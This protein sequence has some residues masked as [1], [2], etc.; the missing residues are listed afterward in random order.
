M[1]AHIGDEVY[2]LLFL[3][4]DEVLWLMNFNEQSCVCV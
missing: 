4:Y 3:V 1:S 2:E